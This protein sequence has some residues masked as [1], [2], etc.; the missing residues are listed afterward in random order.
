V[1]GHVFLS[2]GGGDGGQY[3]HRLA[4][5]LTEQGIAVWFDKNLHPGD[6]WPGILAERIDTSSAV[7]VIMTP[8]A[9]Q[10]R[11]VNREILRAE[12]STRPIVP[13]LLAGRP[14]FSLADIEYG[15]VRGG[16]LPPAAVV[17][18][19]RAL[20]DRDRSTPVGG[21]DEMGMAGVG[22]ARGQSGTRLWPIV[23]GRVPHSPPGLLTRP[24]LLDALAGLRGSSDAVILAAVNGARGVGKT[25]VAAQ[26]AR[27]AVAHRW[28]VVVWIDAETEDTVVAGLAALASV[29]GLATHDRTVDSA[30]DALVWLAT[31]PGPG[32]IVYDNVNDPDML[33]RWTPP[34]STVQI[35]VTTVRASV[36]DLGQPINVDVFTPEEAAEFLN[37]RT[38]LTDVDGAR[39]VASELGFLP[40]AVAQ[41]AALIGPGRGRIYPTYQSY[42]RAFTTAST[43]DRSLQPVPGS[44][45]PHSVAQAIRLSLRQVEHADPTGNAFRLLQLLAVLAPTGVPTHLLT[46]VFGADPG[47]AGPNLAASVALI[48]EYALAVPDVAGATLSMHRLTQ[49]VIHDDLAADGHLVD[50]VARA[51]GL[52]ETAVPSDPRVR[53]AWPFC[54]V[55]LPHALA[56]LD[57]LSRSM[58][59]LAQY[60]GTSGDYTTA[61][62]VW[63]TLSAAYLEAVG[64]EHPE[65]LTVMGNLARWIGSTGEVVTARDQFKAL[66]PVMERV[67]GP[68]HPETLGARSH[69][70]FWTGQAGE[71]EAA[72]DQ[73]AALLPVMESV[74]GPEHPATLTD[75]ANFAFFTGTTGHFAVA[76][77]LYATL[78][79]VR[80]RVSGADH[81]DTLAVRT[82]LAR[83]TGD[84]GD[85]VA[86]RDMY[87]A[88]V[89]VWERV[90]G[91]EHPDTLVA[92]A[93]L[94]YY[95]GRA[96]NAEAARSLCAALQP[97][98]ERVLGPEHPDTL[99]NR[100][101][102]ARWTGHSGD[103]VAARDLYTALV[104]VW[105]RAFGAEHPDT[106][107]SRA[108]LARWTGEAGDAI[109]A[110]DLYTTL[111]PVRERV[112]GAEH[113]D[114]LTVHADLAY[115][116]TQAEE[117]GDRRT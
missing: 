42:L 117:A 81:P 5:H 100:G 65:T 82:N 60:P 40:L 102:V 32:V 33:T 15:D 35:V 48:T 105:E 64:P 91:A 27:R 57:P 45:Y 43:T 38:R 71:V 59:Q 41:A 95:T 80:E 69:I 17:A 70:A 93:N 16:V 46:P 47:V 19:L 51:A 99:T 13:L 112:S 63:T 24:Q 54:A 77:D 76:R 104:P 66:L 85:A 28:P 79:P 103:A 113:P 26:Y 78:L 106:L 73:F 56:V 31:H 58:W 23:V 83:W 6:E 52:I 62:A 25:Q 50:V 94:A 90:S 74:L 115:W 12:A 92:R 34:V 61:I 89:P 109:A 9:E 39:R 53:E 67:L 84:A 37:E 14:F 1:A 96:G 111:L 101:N 72:R 29:A 30:R 4:R 3:V 8:Q 75:R 114:T 86:A 20:V 116:T 55:L 98:M 110:R 97:V 49:R 21:V 18:R 88:L 36:A 10:A 22:P 87:T 108:N 68:E 44:D 11:W 107:V 2:Y 7:V